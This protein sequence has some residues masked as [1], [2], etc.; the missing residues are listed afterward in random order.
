MWALSTCRRANEIN[1]ITH[2]FFVVPLGDGPGFW[3]TAHLLLP[4]ALL[5]IDSKVGRMSTVVR[6]KCP[7]YR[8]AFNQGPMAVNSISFGSSHACPM[9]NLTK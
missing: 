9:A 1:Q 8:E 7:T 3:C 6:H 2:A 5:T 4:Y